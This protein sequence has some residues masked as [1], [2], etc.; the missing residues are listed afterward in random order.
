MPIWN[1]VL[2]QTTYANKDQIQFRVLIWIEKWMCNYMSIKVYE[3]KYKRDT[4]EQFL[5]WYPIFDSSP[6]PQ[7]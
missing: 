5:K 4:T 3:N 1:I 2:L 7:L 6:L